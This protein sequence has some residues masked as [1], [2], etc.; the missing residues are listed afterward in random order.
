MSSGVDDV[1]DTSSELGG[2][3]QVPH[4]ALGSWDVTRLEVRQ[5]SQLFEVMLDAVVNVHK[6]CELL[7]IVKCRCV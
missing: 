3:G 5:R 4:E 6:F 1:V 7:P 2:F